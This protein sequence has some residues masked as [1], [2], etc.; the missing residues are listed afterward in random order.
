MLA[1]TRYVKGPAELA[2][3][4]VHGAAGEIVAGALMDAAS[5]GVVA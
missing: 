4:G 5:A 3:I 2:P 1:R